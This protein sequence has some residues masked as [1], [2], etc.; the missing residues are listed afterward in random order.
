[1]ND[2]PGPRSSG[3]A[4]L[5]LLG[6]LAAPVT[7]DAG[8]GEAITAQ[9]FHVEAAVEIDATGKVAQA[10]PDPHVHPSLA[11]GMLDVVNGLEFTPLTIDGRSVTGKTHVYLRGC[12]VPAEGGLRV[13]YDVTGIGPGRERAN[14]RYPREAVLSNA[15]GLFTVLYRVQPDGRGVVEAITPEGRSKAKLPIFKPVI[16]EWIEGGTYV[17]E[18]IDGVAVTTRMRRQIEFLA[19][20]SRRRT[21]DTVSS[22]ACQRAATDGNAVER[23]DIALDSAFAL[24][25]GS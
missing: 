3:F 2:A 19:P 16:L 6:L 17:P 7:V 5:V 4:A 8:D 9:E 23:D 20:G 13:A 12:A 10:A 21:P 1:M 11:D 18:V 15:S 25:A 22:S 14:P 24:K